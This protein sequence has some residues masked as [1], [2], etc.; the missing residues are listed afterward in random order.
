M[1]QRFLVMLV[2][3]TAP[4]RAEPTSGSSYR[5]QTIVVDL[6]GMAALG[7]GLLE[8]GKAGWH[9]PV[10]GTLM[11]VGIT[12]YFVGAPIV[13]AVNGNPILRSIGLRVAPLVLGFVVAGLARDCD[14]GGHECAFDGYTEGAASLLLTVP[15]ALAIDWFVFSDR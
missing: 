10:G 11:A 13:H 8:A 12:D 6:A 3:L 7:I 9:G 2:L 4:A 1:T 15:A 14:H 5:N